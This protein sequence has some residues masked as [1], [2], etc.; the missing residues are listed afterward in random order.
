MTFK[1]DWEKASTK[2][3]IPDSVIKEMLFTYYSKGDIASIKRLDGGCANVNVMVGVKSLKEPI[4][5]R[6][7]L[8]NPTSAYIE[9]RVSSILRENLPVPEFYHVSQ[10]SG[11]TFAL[12]EHLPGITLR[13][14]LLN[15]KNS[16]INAIMFEVGKMLSMLTTIKFSRGGFFNDKLDIVEE[17]TPDGLV[18][19]CLSSLDDSNIKSV[20]SEKE[21]NNIFDL[22]NRYSGFLEPIVDA[23]LVHGDFDPANILVQEQNG[24]IKITGILDWEFCFSGSTLCDVANMLRYVHHMQPEYQDYFLKGL[25]SDGYTLPEGWRVTVGLLNLASLLDCLKRADIKS[26]PNQ[27]N[28]IKSLI[29]YILFD[30]SKINVVQYNENWPALFVNESNKIKLSLGGVCVGVHHVGSTSVPGLAAKDTIDVIVEVKDLSFSRTLLKNLGYKYSGEF[31]LPLRKSFTYRSPKI[32]VNL[33]IFEKN[34]PEVELNILF[35]DYLRSHPQVRDRYASL[36]YQLLEDEGSQR[37]DGP[38]YREYTLKKHE[39]IRG[40]LEKTGFNRLRIVICAHDTEWI[41]ARKFRNLY[42]FKPNGISDDPYAWTFAHNQ[43]RHFILY[44]GV[45]IIGYAHLQLWP[46]KRAA[47]R[48]IAIDDVYRRKGYG[49]E[50]VILIEKWLKLLKYKS[51]HVESKQEVAGFYKNLNY[52]IIPFEDPDGYESCIEDVPMGKIL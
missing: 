14:W 24:N 38:M 33:H 27:I 49:S 35:R 47:M 18:A 28:D 10:K 26:S 50:F 52:V 13:D 43:H 25:L 39:F 37:K 34:D 20:L 41:A 2:V 12:V 42:F 32:N 22:F 4:I 9:Q 23:N 7:Y 11:Y 8:R 1:V 3:H 19:F 31:N 17:I 44:K 15:K 5:L 21:I 30:M 46:D 16:N 45:N 51:I 40:V 29:G 48:I 36:K 6:I